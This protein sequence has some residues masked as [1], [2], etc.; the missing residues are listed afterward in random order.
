MIHRIPQRTPEWFALRAPYLTASEADAVLA[1]AGT[2]GRTKLRLR[3]ALARLGGMPRS[4][5]V[6]TPAM[7][8]GREQEEAAL[9]AYE[10]IAGPVDRVGFVS[11]PTRMIGCS[12]DGICLD[13]DDYVLGG[14]EVK[15]PEAHT[16]DAYLRNPDALIADYATQV[17][18]TLLVTEAPYWDLVSYGP[19]FPSASRLLVVRMQWPLEAPYCPWWVD[20]V[21]PVDV[22]AYTESVDV[23]LDEVDAKVAELQ[24]RERERE[25]VCNG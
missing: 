17:T 9:R 15:V 25:T 4:S 24:A 13:Y 23:F 19:D 18:H 3:I 22:P 2:V 6:D 5:P 21:V 8:Y 1:K 14:V 20:R 11:H 7:R 10:V 12:P 16:H